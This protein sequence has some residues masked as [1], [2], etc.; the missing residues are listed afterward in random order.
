MG[1][2]QPKFGRDVLLTLQNHH[3]KFYEIWF[4]FG[5]EKKKVV[6]NGHNGRNFYKKMKFKIRLVA[7]NGIRSPKFSRK[8]RSTR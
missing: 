7:R 1:F 5:S 8:V 3:I 4:D 2:G 6:K